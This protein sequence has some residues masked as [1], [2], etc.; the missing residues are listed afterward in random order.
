VRPSIQILTAL[1]VAVLAAVSLW[2]GATGWRDG[3]VVSLTSLLHYSLDRSSSPIGHWMDVLLWF[4]AAVGETYL[5]W[6][7]FREARAEQRRRRHWWVR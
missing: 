5:A 3:E 2:A 4:V 7:L 1:V 6:A